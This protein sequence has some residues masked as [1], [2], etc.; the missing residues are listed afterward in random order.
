[1]INALK[2]KVPK[3]VNEF[4][5]PRQILVLNNKHTLT[6]K[7]TKKYRLTIPKWFLGGFADMVVRPTYHLVS[8]ALI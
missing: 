4:K 2:S 5:R 7:S 3:L 1:M 6:F 8:H